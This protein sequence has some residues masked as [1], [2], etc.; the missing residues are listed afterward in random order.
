MSTV[1]PNSLG[2]SHEDCS[3]PSNQDRT[4]LSPFTDFS[5][6]DTQPILIKN[7]PYS[8]QQHVSLAKL[9]SFRVGGAAEFFIAP[10]TLDELQAALSWA[11]QQSVP[12]TLIGAG[13]NLLISDRGLEGLVICM[14][15]MKQVQ[16]E[17]ET[18]QVTASAGE[19]LARLAWRA[20]DLGLS[21]LEWAVGIPGTVG[22]A[23][24]MNAGAHAWCAA[25]ILINAHTL[26]VGGRRQ[27][28]QPHDLAF[29]YRTSLI[30][31]SDLLVTQAS[32]Q[33]KPGQSPQKVIE[34]TREHMKQ[35]HQ[36]QPYHLP[37]CGSVFR[38]P[39]SQKAGWLI[40]QTGLKGY[41]IGDA[42]VAQQH[43]NFIL[44]LGHATASDIFCLIQHVQ[45]QVKDQWTLLL[46]PEVK[47][48]GEF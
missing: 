47:F 34:D 16:F 5:R 25:D 26:D 3:V 18:G 15:G 7:T 42:Q 28:F 23:V 19:S 45:E 21:G 29:D 12:V 20:A 6:R 13:S 22:G 46:R 17:A 14:R 24:V 30:Q 35:R 40:E 9:T 39:E 10:R 41:Q 44:N 27:I 38:N 8:I 36:T 32:F 11:D 1:T 31:N 43:A 37:S 2:I 48:I 4:S 33:L